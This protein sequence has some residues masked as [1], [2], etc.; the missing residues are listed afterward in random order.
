MTPGF[1]YSTS[2]AIVKLDHE[3][4]L[5]VMLVG[6]CKCK[7]SR[8]YLDTIS[9]YSKTPAIVDVKVVKNPANSGN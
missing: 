7:I 2:S 4:D 9:K 5:A 3:A 1:T 8:N 6:N